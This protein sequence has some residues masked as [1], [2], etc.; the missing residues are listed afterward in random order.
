MLD[1]ARLNVLVHIY[2]AFISRYEEVTVVNEDKDIENLLSK[3]HYIPEHSNKIT[4]SVL[5]R[6]FLL[7]YEAS[8]QLVA[9]KFV[10]IVFQCKQRR[11]CYLD[12]IPVFVIFAVAE[13]GAQVVSPAYLNH[14]CVAC[15]RFSHELFFELLVSDVI[16]EHNY[17]ASLVFDALYYS[18]VTLNNTSCLLLVGNELSYGICGLI[19][20]DIIDFF[21]RTGAIV[22]STW[23]TAIKPVKTDTGLIEAYSRGVA[24]LVALART[25]E[26]ALRPSHNDTASFINFHALDPGHDRIEKPAFCEV[27]I[28]VFALFIDG[29]SEF[30]IILTRVLEVVDVNTLDSGSYQLPLFVIKVAEVDCG[31]LTHI[32]HGNDEELFVQENELEKGRYY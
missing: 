8:D 18:I 4:C 32:K 26:L 21:F 17:E 19:D 12:G 25:G 9:F 23:G 7:L 22:V 14:V 11:R 28:D 15:C 3:V 27:D 13:P 6:H 1:L 29:G 20:S 10:A 2:V 5:P 24:H 30:R 16:C 31:K